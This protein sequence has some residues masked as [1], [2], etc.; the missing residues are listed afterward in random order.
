MIVFAFK[1]SAAL[2]ANLANKDLRLYEN[3]VM[4]D[5]YSIFSE[6]ES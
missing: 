5:Q 2:L 1:T 4:Y 6:K 3:T